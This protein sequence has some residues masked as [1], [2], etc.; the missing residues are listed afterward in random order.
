MSFTPGPWIARHFPTGGASRWETWI[1]DS[2][3]DRDGKVV[4]NA[5]CRLTA[6]NDNCKDNA[7]IIAAAPDLLAACQEAAAFICNHESGHC[8]PFTLVYDQ[9]VK[10]IC[11]AEG[12]TE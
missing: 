12:A 7:A 11:K 10:A 4:A 6:T 5:V 3:P 2:I 1:I 8:E 9:L